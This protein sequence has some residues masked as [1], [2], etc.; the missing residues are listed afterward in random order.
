MINTIA[1]ARWFLDKFFTIKYPVAWFVAQFTNVTGTRRCFHFGVYTRATWTTWTTWTTT[2]IVGTAVIST[3]PVEFPCFPVRG[4]RGAVF[5]PMAFNVA[6]VAGVIVGALGGGRQK[7]K[8]KNWRTK[9]GLNGTKTG[10]G[11]EDRMAKNRSYKDE[12]LERH[13]FVRWL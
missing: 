9:T 2:T 5:H 13:F 8:K 6:F 3:V 10:L 7:D 4:V 12:C 1:T 11:A